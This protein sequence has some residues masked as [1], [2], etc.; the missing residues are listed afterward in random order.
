M[1]RSL[2]R[3]RQQAVVG[4]CC[5]FD[6]DCAAG[7]G[8]IKHTGAIPTTKQ[9]PAQPK[10]LIETP[11]KTTGFALPGESECPSPTTEKKKRERLGYGLPSSSPFS[12]TSYHWYISRYP[13]APCP[14]ILHDH[15]TGRGRDTSHATLSAPSASSQGDTEFDDDEGGDDD[16]LRAVR[17]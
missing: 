6:S 12:L 5:L 16:D 15:Q 3:I 14:H 11:T 17:Q 1:H 2:L 4:S 8:C 13:H 10:A 9:G 7:P